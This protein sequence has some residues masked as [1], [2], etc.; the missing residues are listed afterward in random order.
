LNEKDKNI[1]EYNTPLAFNPNMVAPTKAEDKA[2]DSIVDWDGPLD[3]ENPINWGAGKKK[4]NV[5]TVG[6]IALLV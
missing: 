4:R 3:Q 6:M 2:K 1:F 5:I